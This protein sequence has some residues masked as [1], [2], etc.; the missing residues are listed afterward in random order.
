MASITSSTSDTNGGD[1]TAEFKINDRVIYEGD[2]G[3]IIDIGV[4]EATATDEFGVT[5]VTKRVLVYLFQRDSPVDEVSPDAVSV[6]GG[7][8]LKPATRRK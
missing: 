2:T 6:I 8:K 7:D 1:V 3:T 5:T 4:K